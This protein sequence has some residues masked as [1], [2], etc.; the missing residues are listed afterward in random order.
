LLDFLTTLW[1]NLTGQPQIPLQ[2]KDAMGVSRRIGAPW[3]VLIETSDLRAQQLLGQY[4]KKLSAQGLPTD[5]QGLW[6]QSGVA[7]LADN[8]GKT[9]LPAASLTK[10]AT[11][12]AALETWGPQH[13]FDTLIATDGAVQNGVLQGNLIV[14]GSGDP[15]FVTEEAIALGVALNQIGIRQVTGDLVITGN[16]MMNFEWEALKSGAL[17]K[18]ALNAGTWS[19][20]MT[21][22]FAKLPPNAKLTVKPQVAIAGNVR[23]AQPVQ[24]SLLIQHQSLPLWNLIKRLNIYSN[25]VMAEMLSRLVG[26]PQATA[27]KAAQAA[28]VSPNE[29]LLANG[30]GLGVE[31]RI[32]PHAVAAMF[33]AVKRYA[34]GQ[35]MTIA[36]LFPIA[37]T[38]KGT[39]EDR[40]IPIYT[41]V[42]TGT[43][44][45]VSALAGFLPTRDQG[46][47]VFSVINRGANLDGLRSSQDLLLQQGQSLWGKPPARPMELTPTQGITDLTTLGIMQRNRVPAAPK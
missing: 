9:P 21:D 44:N 38:D 6:M 7:L 45:D 1:I 41:V 47:V 37:G 40:E 10:V 20:D 14:Q 23:Y 30:S 39:V 16:F 12:L 32:S 33:A 17:L 46:V 35:G 36:D 5:Q 19:E 8:Q 28:G 4:L 34:E 15:M 25:N 24:A 31:N 11:S 26:G 18:Q 42:K 13:Q 43:L 29:V 2:I 27:A 22:T 3:S